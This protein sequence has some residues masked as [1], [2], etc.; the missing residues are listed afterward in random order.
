MAI[1]EGNSCQI[2]LPLPR[3]IDT[4]IFLR[5]TVRAKALT[6]LLTTANQDE[7]PTPSA[8]GSFV[9]ALPDVSSMAFLRYK[10][11]LSGGLGGGGANILFLHPAPQRFNSSQPISTVIYNH[12][13]TIDFTERLAK[14]LARRSGIP[15]YVGNSASFANCP[16]GGTVEEEM[17]IFRRVASVITENLGQTVES[18]PSTRVD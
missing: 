4:R 8:L 14:F 18:V 12:E 6:L 7:P 13:S 2:S 16:E 5:L 10:H 3:S 15:V 9:Y 11:G 17:D 1:T